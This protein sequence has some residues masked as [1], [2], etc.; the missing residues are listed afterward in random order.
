MLSAFELLGQTQ[1]GPTYYLNGD[2]IDINTCFINPL[3]ID[4]INV[5]KKTG[6][7]VIH[8]K[9]KKKIG[10]LT[11]DNVLSMFTNVKTDNHVVFMI[12]GK[13]VR[14]KAPVRIDG[15]FFIYVVTKPL[16]EV[17]YID[18]SFR[19]LKLVEITLSTKKIEPKIVIRGEEFMTS[20]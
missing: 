10:F 2:S 19:D 8:L 13:I 17:K 1:A 4:N 9:S 14:D 7:G 11:L 18:E 12:D 15:S 5:D 6:H 20:K 16:N 3:S